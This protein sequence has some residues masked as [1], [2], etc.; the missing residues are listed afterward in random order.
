L[1]PDEDRALVNLQQQLPAIVIE[2]PE[3]S[4]SNSEQQSRRTSLNKS[5]NDIRL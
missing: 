4:A 2:Q 3:P 1:S 5:N